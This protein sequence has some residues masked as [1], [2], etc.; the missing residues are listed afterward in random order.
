MLQTEPYKKKRIRNCKAFKSTVK[1]SVAVAF[2][3]KMTKFP[4]FFIMTGFSADRSMQGISK[5]FL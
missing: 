4:D 3:D 1:K 5:T 2:R